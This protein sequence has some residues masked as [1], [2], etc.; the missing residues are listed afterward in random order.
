MTGPDGNPVVHLWLTR[1]PKTGRVAAQSR[2]FQYESLPAR[3][4]AWPV[5]EVDVPEGEFAAVLTAFASPDVQD[6][7][8]KQWWD[9]AGEGSS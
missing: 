3:R 4:A 7:L 2:P 9:Q 8:H 5:R 6:Q 1:D